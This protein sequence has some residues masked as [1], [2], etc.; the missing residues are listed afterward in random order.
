MYE[1]HT[2]LSL[3]S[4]ISNSWVLD[5]NYDFYICKSLQELQKIKSLK[6]GDFKLY[7]AEGESIQAEAVGTKILKLPY[8]KILELTSCYYMPKIIRNI[9]SIPLLLK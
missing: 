9:I 5:T 6:K 1:I 3:N 7:E 8:E 2:I 4:F